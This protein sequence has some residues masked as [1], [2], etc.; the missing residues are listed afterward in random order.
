MHHRTILTQLFCLTLLA[1]TVACGQS[2]PPADK[3]ITVTV[4]RTISP[5]DALYRTGRMQHVSPVVVAAMPGSSRGVEEVEVVFFALRRRVD[6]EELK[7]EY[8]RRGLAPADPYVLAAV[9]AMDPAFAAGSP[10]GTHW[11]NAE[12]TWCWM[13]FTSRMGEHGV[14]VECS[15]EVWPS[16]FWFA[17]VRKPTKASPQATLSPDLSGS[18]RSPTPRG[19]HR[20]AGAV[21]IK[22]RGWYTQHSALEKHRM[23]GILFPSV[24]YS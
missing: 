22:K 16:D 9:N 2:D 10:N 14:K 18:F 21:R 12:G 3:V 15:Y 24:P 11:K 13:T 4:D 7:G 23:L 1:T 8:L 17:G 6:E 20:H 19:L 5:Q